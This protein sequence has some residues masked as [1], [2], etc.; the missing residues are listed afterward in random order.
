MSWLPKGALLAT[1]LSLARS[2]RTHSH[3]ALLVVAC[4]LVFNA[5]FLCY[6]IAPRVCHRFVGYLEEEAVK[7]YTK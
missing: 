3:T 5:F 1:T 4:S 2:S 6:L 7:T